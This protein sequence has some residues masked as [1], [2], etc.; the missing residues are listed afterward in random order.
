MGNR[1]GAKDAAHVRLHHWWMESEAYRDLKPVSR[2]LLHEL[3]RLAG[4]D[5]NG[6]VSLGRRRAAPLLRVNPDTVTSAYEE[7]VEHGFIQLSRE[8]EW[9]QGKE[10]EWRVTILPCNGHEP[11]HDW[12]QW[13]PGQPVR[14]PPRRRPG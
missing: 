12:Q 3:M 4:R 11:T 9:Q 10:R 7:L 6:R 2:C 1:A 8:E 13:Q 14:K 5:K